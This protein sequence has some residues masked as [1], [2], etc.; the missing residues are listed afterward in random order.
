MRRDCWQTLKSKHSRRPLDGHRC[1][2]NTPPCPGSTEARRF[3][4]W[5]FLRI[6]LMRNGQKSL[7]SGEEILLKKFVV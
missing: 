1:T 2:Y 4:V 7:G 3:I 5:V 6:S